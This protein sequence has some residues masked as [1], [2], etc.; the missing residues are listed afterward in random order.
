VLV[1]PYRAGN[2]QLAERYKHLLTK[3]R[4]VRM[5]E[6]THDRLRAAAQFRAARGA[7]TP[8]AVDL[9]SAPGAGCKTF[10]TRIIECFLKGSSMQ[11]FGRL[12]HDQILP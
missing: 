12:D 4:G 2:R 5:V 1:V 9:V 7:K 3:R 11:L 8:D 6:L 10:V